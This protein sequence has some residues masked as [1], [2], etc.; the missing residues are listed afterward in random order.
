M[1]QRVKRKGVTRTP[2]LIPISQSVLKT[3]QSPLLS[4]SSRRSRQAQHSTQPPF[5]QRAG[6]VRLTFRTSG[7]SEHD[8]QDGKPITT[9]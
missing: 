1:L 2:F 6:L 5:G 4:R 3:V 9:S 7:L 8:G